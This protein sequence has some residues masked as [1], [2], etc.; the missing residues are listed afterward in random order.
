MLCYENSLK[1]CSKKFILPFYHLLAESAYLPLK[2]L[3]SFAIYEINYFQ[4]K[5]K[6]CNARKTVLCSVK[7]AVV[8]SA[9]RTVC[10]FPLG[11]VL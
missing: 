6:N 11:S 2:Y 7:F 3:N 4:C 10:S 1:S 9:I 5:C 8:N